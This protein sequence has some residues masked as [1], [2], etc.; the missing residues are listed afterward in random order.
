MHLV[1]HALEGP[2]QVDPG[3]RSKIITIRIS[4]NPFSV[5]VIPKLPFARL[6]EVTFASPSPSRAAEGL[7]DVELKSLRSIAGVDIEP[8][9]E[10]DM[11]DIAAPAERVPIKLIGITVRAAQAE[12][13]RHSV[14]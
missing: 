13:R 1:A 7:I 9:I 11:A 4:G 2:H 6:V 14:Q 12:L 10:D 3:F 5:Q 8:Y